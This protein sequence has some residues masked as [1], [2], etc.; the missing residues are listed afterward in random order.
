MQ[1]HDHVWKDGVKSW[2]CWGREWGWCL[3]TSTVP[4]RPQVQSQVTSDPELNL[5][6]NCHG[7]RWPQTR[8]LFIIIK[9]NININIFAFCGGLLLYVMLSDAIFMVCPWATVLQH[10][11]ISHFIT[12]FRAM[13]LCHELGK[14]PSRITPAYEPMNLGVQAI[15]GH[16]PWTCGRNGTV[17]D[18]TESIPREMHTSQYTCTK[19]ICKCSNS[20]PKTEQHF[21]P[22]PKMHY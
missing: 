7:H 12:I 21:Q 5:F 3:H 9:C 22:Q 17:L 15:M 10:T 11:L 16:T 20:L 1:N 8:C 2:Y 18:Q 4:F 13:N 14:F 19:K 6:E